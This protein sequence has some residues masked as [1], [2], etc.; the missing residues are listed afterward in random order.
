MADPAPA[1]ME[2][3]KDAVRAGCNAADRHLR[4]SYPDC[5]CPT[6][7]RAIKAAI[8]AWNTRPDTARAEWADEDVERA[9]EA[10][11]NYNAEQQAI[12][13][14]AHGYAVP[15]STQFKSWADM[16]EHERD[17]VRKVVRAAL[18]V[19]PASGT[20]ARAEWNAAVEECAKV[21]R[22]LMI[23]RTKVLRDGSI[24]EQCRTPTAAEISKAIRS[25]ARPSQAEE[26]K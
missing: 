26:E 5:G 4:C 13:C 22:D 19:L 21:A 2:A 18:V 20:V 12:E 8:A 3:I 14:L 1:P 11:Q 24:V 15:D 25:L 16:E 23:C 7:P 10:M 9:A 6:F 17:Y